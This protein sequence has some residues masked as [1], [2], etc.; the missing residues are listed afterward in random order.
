MVSAN[1]HEFNPG[2]D[3]HAPHDAFVMKPVDIQILLECIG[4]V[5]DIRWSF[6]APSPLLESSTAVASNS[7]PN[8]AQ[9]H[10]DDLIQL[11]RI[12]HVRGIQSKLNELES[13]D[14]ETKPFA[15]HLR[16][17]I[18][19]FDLKSYMQALE[20]MRKNG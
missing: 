4:T 19:N 15:A 5:L 10:I 3:E 17:L 14:P 20:A 8:H 1:G 6:E 13:A 16:K 7:V 12:G 18:T 11:G 2:G 9:H